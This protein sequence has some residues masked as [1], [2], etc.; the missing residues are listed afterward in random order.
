MMGMGGTRTGL[1]TT[2]RTMTRRHGDVRSGL[3]RLRAAAGQ[4]GVCLGFG[5]VGQAQPDV[6]FR[7]NAISEHTCRRSWL[8]ST[9]W[10]LPRDL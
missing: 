8:Y 1:A 10:L 7:G 2:P 6:I 5:S 9:D 4:A 3:R